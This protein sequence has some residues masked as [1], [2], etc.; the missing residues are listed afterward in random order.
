MESGAVMDRVSAGPLPLQR[1]R[2]KL[3]SLQSGSSTP[4]SNLSRNVVGHVDGS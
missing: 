3:S 2:E 1:A 4:T